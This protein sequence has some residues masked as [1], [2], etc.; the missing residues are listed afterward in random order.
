MKLLKKFRQYAYEGGWE[1]CPSAKGKKLLEK[2]GFG[3][4]AKK[5]E[6]VVETPKPKAKKTRRKKITD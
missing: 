5:V 6:K 4:V 3:P 1:A 2:A